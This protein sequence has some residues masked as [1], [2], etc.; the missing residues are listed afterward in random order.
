MQVDI[1]FRNGTV[2]N[3]TGSP[4]FVGDVAIKG[5][6]IHAVGPNLKVTGTR[7]VDVTGKHIMP[8]WTDIHTHL[9]VQCMWDPLLS[10]SGPGGVTTVVMG[11]CG[12]GAAPTR[13]GGRDFMINTLSAVEDIPGEVIREGAKWTV[14][15]KDWESFPEYL[16]CLE[17]LSTVCDIATMV[18]HS[19]VRGYVLGPELANLSD[20]PG[21]P[22]THPLTRKD[23]EAIAACVKESVEA[24]ALGF[25]ITRWWEHRD[26]DGVLCAGTLADADELVLCAKAV[27]EGGGCMFQMHNDFKSYDDIP[28]DKMDMGLRKE[29]F[30][31]EWA[32]MRFIAKE[33]GLTVNWLGGV[34]CGR[35]RGPQSRQPDFG[36]TAILDHELA[37]AHP[38]IRQ[39][40]AFSRCYQKAPSLRMVRPA[41]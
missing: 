4:A 2:V 12:V 34:G 22:W 31:R 1:V 41:L 38:P 27:A 7:E 40:E 11:S 18:P 6:E 20:K 32:W 5:G 23:K 29:H 36:P 35:R 17:G 28:E 25:S 30:K 14:D 39:H 8:G 3:G 9:D 21:G 37:I 19:C 24:G 33:Y 15:G 13:K 16:K 10:P 26:A